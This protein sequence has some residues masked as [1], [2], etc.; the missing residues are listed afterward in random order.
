MRP[1]AASVS[2]LR[3]RDLINDLEGHAAWSGRAFLDNWVLG[4]NLFRPHMSPKGRLLHGPGD[5]C[6]V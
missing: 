2:L 5:S 3:Y 6:D 1:P 4:Y